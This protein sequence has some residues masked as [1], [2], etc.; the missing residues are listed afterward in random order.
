LFTEPLFLSVALSHFIIDVLNGQTSVVFTYLSGPLGLN[1]TS[2]ALISTAY[3]FSG[4]LTQP[5][6][7][8]LS[9][10]FGARWMVAL[11]VTWM[12]VFFTLGLVISGPAALIFLVL[13]AV[14]SGA[15]HPAGTM[16]AT[17]QGRIHLAGRETTSTS[18]FF[19]FGQSGFFVGPLI[20]G[21]ILDQFGKPG[22]MVI[23]LAAV[24]I[25]LSMLYTMRPKAELARNEMVNGKEVSSA[26]P[27]GVG[28]I[29]LLALVAIGSSW[30]GRSMG[31][32]I[33]KYLNDLGLTASFYGGVAALFMA[34]SACGLIAGG[35]MADR[36]GKRRTASL[37]LML[38]SIPLVLIPRV[39]QTPW[40]FV[41]VPLAGALSG[42]SH[43]ILVVF[44]QRL[45]PAG[46]GLASGLILGF[47]FTSG[48]LGALVSGFAAD[49]AGVGVVFPFAAGL[50]LISAL[51]A[52]RLPAR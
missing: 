31:V 10:R 37:A 28:F 34:G 30:I 12:G 8:Y 50:A 40:M 47:M 13:T 41:V 3:S 6:F 11:G 9:D 18:Y 27:S 48:S 43:S 46:K 17:N 7:G 45:F 39:V 26:E 25:G 24:P 16:E 23:T 14:G 19:I 33:P 52:T 29:L 42:S 15:F 4:A 36:Y 35:W 5:F 2:L 1:N 21:L 51:F 32:F 38:A 44:A 20:A 22:L 49:Q